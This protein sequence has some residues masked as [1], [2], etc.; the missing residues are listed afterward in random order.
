[1]LRAASLLAACAVSCSSFAALTAMQGVGIV[2][3]G[4]YLKPGF[5][6]SAWNI[7]FTFD[8]DTSASATSADF[9]TWT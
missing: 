9:G 7:A 6:P 5:A 4:A 3:D 1:M 2:A 8:G